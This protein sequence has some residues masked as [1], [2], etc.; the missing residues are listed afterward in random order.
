MSLSDHSVLPDPRIKRVEGPNHAL[1]VGQLVGM[2]MRVAAEAA[3]G[4]E[5]DY[6]WSVEMIDFSDGA[7]AATFRVTRPSGAYLVTVEP[8]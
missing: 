8:E 4:S 6:E 5:P 3:L 1:L 2:A 7:H